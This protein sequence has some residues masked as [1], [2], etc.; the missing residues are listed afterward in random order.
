MKIILNILN[1]ITKKKEKYIVFL[2]QDFDHNFEFSL[3]KIKLSKFDS[4]IYWKKID[5]FFSKLEKNILSIN[6]KLL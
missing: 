1:L 5:Y 4:K 2:D 6:I 3:R